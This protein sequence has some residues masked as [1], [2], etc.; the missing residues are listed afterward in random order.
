MGATSQLGLRYP[1]LTD[2][3]NGPLAFQNLANDT[4]AAIT[5]IPFGHI[6][7]TAGFQAISG[8]GSYPTMVSQILKGGMTFSS[9]GLVVPKNGLYQLTL[10]G[11]FTGGGTY[12]CEM[13]ATINSAI[14]PVGGGDSFNALGNLVGW[15]G[16]AQDYSFWSVGHRQLTAGDTIRLWMKSPADST[17][18]TNGYNGSYLEVRYV[19][20]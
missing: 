6:G 4:E 10:K 19:Q 20:P 11:Y 12:S 14:V 16:G 15:K 3:P 2:P 8:N 1:E 5:T 9:N 17:W 18:G 7:R 13:A